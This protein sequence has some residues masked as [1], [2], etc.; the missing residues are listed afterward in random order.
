[1]QRYFL[2]FFLLMTLQRGYCQSGLVLKSGKTIPYS[3][4]EAQPT[5]LEV[6]PSLEK[7]K[8]KIA[9]DSVVGYYKFDDNKD[10]FKVKVPEVTGD[11]EIDYQFLPFSARGKINTYDYIVPYLPANDPAG[12][13]LYLQKGDKFDLLFPYSFGSSKAKSIETLKSYIRDEPSILEIVEGSTYEHTVKNVEQ[14]INKYNLLSFMPTASQNDPQALVSFYRMKKG[15]SKEPLTLSL[16]GK[17]FTIDTY[18]MININISTKN[19]MKLCVGGSQTKTCKLILG[20]PYFRVYYQVG[21]S[22][23]GEATIVNKDRSA[24]FADIKII[25]SQKKK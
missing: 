5:Y 1:M 10:I 19:L 23:T 22:K 7:G 11:S 16:D 14:L 6:W 15:E 13:Y 18:K 2:L 9:I 24:A 4:M 17:E 25:R 12:H 3:R 21:L 20:L 8:K